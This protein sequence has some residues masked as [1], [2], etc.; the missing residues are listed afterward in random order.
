MYNHSLKWHTMLMQW[1]SCGPPYLNLIRC[2]CISEKYSFASLEVEVPKPVKQ[3]DIQHHDIQRN[4]NLRNTK[5]CISVWKYNIYHELNITPLHNHQFLWTR[6]ILCATV[7]WPP[8][9]YDELG[10]CADI[11][12]Y[13]S[14]LHHRRG[15]ITLNFCYFFYFTAFNLHHTYV[16]W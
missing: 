4:N 8:H 5:H 15:H 11:H 14:D 12:S 6:S 9:F 1:S 7:R 16:I 10:N 13:S 2:L 3:H